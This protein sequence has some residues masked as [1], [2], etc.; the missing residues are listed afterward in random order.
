MKSVK[1]S[2]CSTA[3]QSEES[4]KEFVWIFANLNVLIPNNHLIYKFHENS[5]KNR[6]EMNYDVK[7]KPSFTKL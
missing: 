7:N 5:R 3:D 4:F 1:W 6:I 2:I